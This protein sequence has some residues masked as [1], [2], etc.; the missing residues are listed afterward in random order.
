MEDEA[1]QLITKL[2]RFVSELEPG[3]RALFA[4]LLAPGVARAYEP[5]VSGFDIVS[6]SEQALPA[7]LV[8]ALQESGVRVVGLDDQAPT[9]G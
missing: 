8:T 9:D 5:E 2:R 4:Q 7:S 6:W 1:Q 3:E